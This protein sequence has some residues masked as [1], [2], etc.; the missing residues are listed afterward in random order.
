VKRGREVAGTRETSQNFSSGV[1]IAIA[2]LSRINRLTAMAL[3]IGK[4]GMRFFSVR[5]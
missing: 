3:S 4:N 2:I 1:D 5:G